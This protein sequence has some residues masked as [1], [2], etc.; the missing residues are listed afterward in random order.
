MNGIYLLLGSNLGDRFGIIQSSISEISKR[1][2]KVVAESSMYI[3]DP[4]GY[5]NQPRYLN[6]VVQVETTLSPEKIL[7]FIN[8]IEHD[9]G[10][11]RREKWK[12]RLIDID[13]LYY[14]NEVLNTSSLNI[15]HPQ[16]PFRKFTLIPLNE[17]AAN[18]IHPVLKKTQKEL[19]EENDDTLLVRKISRKE[20]YDKEK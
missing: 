18:E 16:I 4:W 14:Q 15:P 10:R 19:L 5:E 17:I 3:T 9:F 20:Y 11:V 8:K 13:I 7:E 1:I 6:K 12:E 2:G